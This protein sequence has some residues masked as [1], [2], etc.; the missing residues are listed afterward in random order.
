M[1]H[2]PFGP[3][4]AEDERGD[5]WTDLSEV[6]DDLYRQD[7][8]AP[9]AVQRRLHSA[10]QGRADDVIL[11]DIAEHAQEDTASRQDPLGSWTGVPDTDAYET[12]TQD[13]DDL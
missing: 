12:P 5:F 8:A 7:P 11:P 10:T 4:G 9:Q 6:R 1:Y 2:E 13:A 3:R